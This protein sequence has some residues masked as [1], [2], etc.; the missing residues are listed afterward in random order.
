MFLRPGLSIA[1]EINNKNIY[2][3]LNM[4]NLVH[5]FSG[6]KIDILMWNS[7]F[8]SHGNKQPGAKGSHHDKSVFFRD[9]I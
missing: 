7:S 1:G 2:S 9:N 8:V 6:Y 3:V 4:Y 5:L